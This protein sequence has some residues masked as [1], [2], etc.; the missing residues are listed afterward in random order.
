MSALERVRDALPE[1]AKDIRL[2]L[3][4]LLQGTTLTPDQ[5]WGVAIAAAVT[6]KNAELM[7]AMREVA[8][9]ETTQAVVSDAIAAAT[10][11]AMN[12]VFYRFRHQIG[13]ETY[14]ERPARL[15][16]NRLVNPSSSRVNFELMSLAVSAI[17]GCETCV[18]AH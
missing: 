9:S 16:M 18:R 12:N 5:R 3:Q 2:N 8:Q 17:N 15:R 4:S 10:L 1:E 14:A 13:K 11:M 6:T 7:R